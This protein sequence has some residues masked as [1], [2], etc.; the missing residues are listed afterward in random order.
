MWDRTAGCMIMLTLSLLAAPLAAEAQPAEKMPRLGLLVP[1]IPPEP[2]TEAFRQ[3]LRDLGYIEG[4]TLTLEVRWDEYHP[5]RWPDLAAGLVRLRVDCIVAGTTA[6]TWAAKHATSTIPIVM[7]VSGDPVGVGLVA[8]LARPRGNVTGL[9]SMS[10]E[11]NGKRLELL[12]A[13][14][15]GLSRVALLLDTGN[16]RRHV[17]LHDHEIA[18]RELGVQLLPLEVHGPDEFVGAFQT[19]IQ[20]HVQALIIQGSP[21]FGTH[22]A[23]LVE[24]ALASRLPTI[25]VGGEYAHAG[26][27]MTYGPSLSDIY[28]RAATYVD[29]ILKGAKPA[30]LPVERPIKFALVL[31]LKTAKALGITF[32]PT[33][34]IQADEVIQ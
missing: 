1:G 2:L 25:A 20:G 3:G 8:S 18:T 10:P 27:L 26:G 32:P 4:Q 19:A 7:P 12:T 22:Q 31:N 21:L 30:D 28:Q 5:E 16:P 34:L 13:A 24:L 33:L 29:K 17:Q 6:A 15:P 23:R 14:V 9:S 11:L